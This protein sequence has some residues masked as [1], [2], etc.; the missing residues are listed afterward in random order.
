MVAVGGLFVVVACGFGLLSAG[1][2]F[3]CRGLALVAKLFVVRWFNSAL[4]TA[5]FRLVVFA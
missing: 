3:A 4:F 5:Y 2:L 1:L